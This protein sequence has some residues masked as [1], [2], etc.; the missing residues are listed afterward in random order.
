MKKILILISLAIVLL[1]LG[2]CAFFTSDTTPAINNAVVETV[3]LRHLFEFKG[4]MEK[5]VK[6]IYLHGLVFKHTARVFMENREP[7][8][9]SDWTTYRGGAVTFSGAENCSL[10]S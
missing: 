7:L 3:N 2:S 10:I 1:P 6:R 4:S 8:L 5:P 9:R